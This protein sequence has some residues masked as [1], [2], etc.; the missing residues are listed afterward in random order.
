MTRDKSTAPP[1]PTG[2]RPRPGRSSSAER[3][4]DARARIN[5]DA[6]RRG[7]STGREG[8][9]AAWRLGFLLGESEEERESAAAAEERRLGSHEGWRKRRI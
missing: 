3:K 7:G 2:D 4:N 1:R 9:G 6:T 8:G 5:R